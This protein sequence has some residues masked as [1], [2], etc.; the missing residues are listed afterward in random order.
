VGEVLMKGQMFL[1]A[2]IIMITGLIV[3][4]TLFSAYEA[5]EERRFQESVL[6]YERLKNI[7]HE[8][9]YIISTGARQPNINGST[10]AYLSNF[11]SYLRGEDTNFRILYIYFFRNETAGK[12]TVSAG[13]YLKETINLTLNTTAENYNILLADGGKATRQYQTTAGQPHDISIIYY[14]GN[15]EYVE[16]F[17]IPGV[18][19]TAGFF[20]ISVES[21]GSVLRKKEFYN[22]TW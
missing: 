11:S 19:M 16:R 22:T 1:I 10:L 2:A 13:N 17:S 6:L 8:Y 21:T 3:L 20:D 4:K 18:N 9:E 12:T 7:E 15:D 14:I 5:T